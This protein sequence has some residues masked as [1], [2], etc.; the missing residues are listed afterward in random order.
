MSRQ[1]Q[2]WK[3]SFERREEKGK[4]MKREKG[5]QTDRQTGRETMAHECW[6]AAQ[7]GV[8]RVSTHTA[9]SQL[10]FLRD[11]STSRKSLGAY[12]GRIIVKSVGNNILGSLTLRFSL[13]NRRRRKISKIATR[14][15]FLIYTFFRYFLFSLFSLQNQ[16][17]LDFL[18]YSKRV[19]TKGLFS[20]SAVL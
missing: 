1:R 7:G 14:N 12:T 17:E 15:C 16:L 4:G 18:E 11:A 3:N 2:K 20:K 10:G 19:Q 13:N 6:T 5:G 8:S 9:S